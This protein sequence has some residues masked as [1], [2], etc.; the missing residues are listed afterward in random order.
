VAA[1]GNHGALHGRA[2]AVIHLLTPM[3]GPHRLLCLGTT[4]A[5]HPGHPLYQPAHLKPRP[6]P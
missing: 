4:R 1:W 2:Q 3:R 5:G 6:L